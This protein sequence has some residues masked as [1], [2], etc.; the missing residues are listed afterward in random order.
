M[1]K[2]NY[3]FA[4][5]TA[6]VNYD[7]FDDYTIFTETA[8]PQIQAA[9]NIDNNESIQHP[10]NLTYTELAPFRLD[11][12]EEISGLSSAYAAL[13]R[14]DD[15]F[16]QFDDRPYATH[17][18][19][20]SSNHFNQASNYDP[21]LSQ[22]EI[23][24]IIDNPSLLGNNEASMSLNTSAEVLSL[25][26]SL[27]PVS[28]YNPKS[29]STITIE[30]HTKTNSIS[31]PKTTA[32]LEYTTISE[33]PVL[34]N[35]NTLGT[36]S[37]RTHSSNLTTHA[38]SSKITIKKNTRAKSSPPKESFFQHFKINPPVK[39]TPSQAKECFFSHFKIKL[40]SKKKTSAT[41]NTDHPKIKRVRL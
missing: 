12:H 27:Q 21:I 9:T 22:A 28:T 31:S 38:S 35:L 18:E 7:E 20:Y 8:A 14:Y 24:F 2:E 13:T 10:D 19:D 30:R 6:E 33:T 26:P 4:S 1:N 11:P 23:D 34:A 5:C 37:D 16:N 36:F 29:Q 25:Q 41:I 32:P 39:L 3:Q 40:P 15:A 17:Y